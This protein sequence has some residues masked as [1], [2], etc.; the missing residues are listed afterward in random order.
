MK[1]SA[2]LLSL[3][4]SSVAQQGTRGSGNAD[5]NAANKNAGGFTGGFTGDF[6][7]GLAGNSKND[8]FF[9]PSKCAASCTRTF[10]TTK[11]EVGANQDT[12]KCVIPDGATGTKECSGG[13]CDPFKEVT[14]SSADVDTEKTAVCGA[15]KN[16]TFTATTISSCRK[17]IQDMEDAK[18]A[19]TYTAPQQEDQET[20]DKKLSDKMK[21]CVATTNAKTFTGDD[22]AK[23][24]AKDADA[25]SCRD[26]VIDETVGEAAAIG[27]FINK[28]ELTQK[29]ERDYDQQDRIADAKGGNPCSRLAAGTAKTRCTKCRVDKT[30][31]DEC[32]KTKDPERALMDCLTAIADSESDAGIIAKKACETAA[33]IDTAVKSGKTTDEAVGSDFANM[34][35][36]IEREVD[37]QKAAKV[38]T[39]AAGG[40]KSKS[41]KELR[42]KCFDDKLK[43]EAAKTN[44]KPLAE[45]KREVE[46][47][48]VD[49]KVT[50]FL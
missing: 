23:K 22:A 24:I 47:A 20:K 36:D 7:G 6:T 41:S 49:G 25:K 11:N 32:T 26:K 39:D 46:E 31:D 1:T 10:D 40:C 17:A 34:F 45:L 50:H 28:D 4:A 8:C 21:V 35:K 9:K 48:A 15:V 14:K 18:A 42:K 5:G 19:G 33:V 12:S 38:L 30:D 2:V 27:D 37:Q 13:D 43:I 3:V 44:A 29:A 16:P